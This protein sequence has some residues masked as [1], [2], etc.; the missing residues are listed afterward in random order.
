[1]GSRRGCPVYDD[2]AHH[3][4]E[5]EATLQAVREMAPGR[6]VAVVFQ[7]HLYSR[8]AHFCA[9]FA[10]ALAKADQ[11]FLAPVY[12]ARETPDQGLP[13]ESIVE[14]LPAGARVELV[15]G[16]EAAVQGARALTDSGEGWT[17]LFVGA[18]DV[19][20]WARDLAEGGVS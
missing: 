9:G 13:A 2:Y 6:K 5:I 4:T 12:P 20:S 16:R 8:T 18:G 15:P 14:A 11:A 19:G 1:M 17:V 3:P 7:P 10:A